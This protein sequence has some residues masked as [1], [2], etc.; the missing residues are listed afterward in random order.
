DPPPPD[1]PARGRLAL[2][3]AILDRRE[4]L[5]VRAALEL[6]LRPALLHGA[7]RP[8]ARPVD[9]VLPLAGAPGDRPLALRPLLIVSARLCG[10]GGSG[11]R[12]PKAARARDPH[13][14]CCRA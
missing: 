12:S 10:R 8:R 1:R 6:R 13:P 4:R 9:R 2:L 3:R 5:R 11:T 14:L 7:P